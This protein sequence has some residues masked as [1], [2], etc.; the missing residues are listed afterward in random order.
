MGRQLFRL[1][2]LG[3]A[4]FLAY[5]AYRDW[6]AKRDDSASSSASRPASRPITSPETTTYTSEKT[7]RME[8]EARAIERR[9]EEIRSSNMTDG[10]RDR[11]IAELLERQRRLAAE[12]E[13]KEP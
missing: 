6:R 1:L 10:E 12:G 5:N 13:S 3:I 11:A 7:R 4:A 2:V 8:A 9:F